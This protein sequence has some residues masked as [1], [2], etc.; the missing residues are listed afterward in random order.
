MPPFTPVQPELRGV[1]GGLHETL[2]HLVVCHVCCPL[3][4]QMRDAQTPYYVV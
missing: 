1:D 3:K 2:L 4:P